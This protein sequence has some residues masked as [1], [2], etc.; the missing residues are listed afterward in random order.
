MLAT[1]KGTHLPHSSDVYASPIRLFCQGL[2]IPTRVFPCATPA[3]VRAMLPRNQ[4]VLAFQCRN[5]IH[6]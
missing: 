5:P 6:R 4:D 1:I 3:E 2:E